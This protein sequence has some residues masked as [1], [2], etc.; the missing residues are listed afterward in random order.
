[1]KTNATKLMALSIAVMGLAS[2]SSTDVYDEH[3]VEKD[4]KAS[5]ADNFA[6]KYPEV[7][8]NQSWDF[9]CK[10]PSYSLTPINNHH[11]K[12]RTRGEEDRYG[13]GT[14]F[15]YGDWYEVDNNTLDFMHKQLPEHKDNRSKGK[16]FYMK[17]PNSEFTIV[18]IYQ[19]IA[20]AVW[21]LHVVI[22]SE[23]YTVWS[24][25]ER[26]Q[27]KDKGNST[28]HTTVRCSYEPNGGEYWNELTFNTDGSNIKMRNGE[29]NTV[30][31]IQS[32]KI[33]F[34]NQTAGEN[35]YFYLKIID[36]DPKYNPGYYNRWTQQSSL[37]GMM[38]AL[39][40]DK[41]ANLPDDYDAMIVG[42]EDADLYLSDWDCNDVVFLIYSQ[43]KPDVIE[44][45]DGTPIVDTRE[46]RYF[47][48]DLG[49]TD[50]FDF[51]DIVIDMKQT[52]TST[53]ILTN[54]VITGIRTAEPVQTAT[55]RHLGGTLPFKLKIGNTELE[56]MGGQSTFQ[57][58]P[59]LEFDVEGWNPD[60]H[61]ISVEVQQ[62]GN[63]GVYNNVRF[64]RAGEAPMIIAVDPSQD[65]MPERQSVPAEW[66]YTE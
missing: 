50:D 52:I 66:F 45:T 25:N 27:I 57:S 15:T 12:A 32:K 54:G 5:Y 64:P 22:G 29:I 26:I 23:D 55:I 58:S 20:S 33:D 8:L 11:N 49:A 14:V 3:I 30:T 37:K 7:S 9:T 10:T 21:E 59:D 31:A 16:P 53:P 34:K 36:G 2:C 56:E 61:N 62:L 41:P 1:M 38:I 17:V 51:N 18:P 35:M 19:G 44:V 47:I 40:V 6:K 60:T 48:E 39:D 42:C 65:W 63:S 13:Y 4:A 43:N 46:A 28:W 24:K